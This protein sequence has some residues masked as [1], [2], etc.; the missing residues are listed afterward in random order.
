MNQE[1]R[2]LLKIPNFNALENKN[3]VD[4]RTDWYFPTYRIRHTQ[5]FGP[6]RNIDQWCKIFDGENS[7]PVKEK[8]IIS[9]P[10]GDLLNQ[11]VFKLI[12]YSK[13]PV[14]KNTELYLEQVYLYEGSRLQLTYITTEAESEEDL[15]N[16][17]LL[18]EIPGCTIECLGPVSMKDMAEAQ[19]KKLK[20]KK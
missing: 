5:Q 19:I 9:E 12:I 1:I 7:Q 16:I 3:G 18:K 8:L 14:I 6:N 15:N 11:S 10:A 20:E 13:R 17:E 4:Q 2:Y